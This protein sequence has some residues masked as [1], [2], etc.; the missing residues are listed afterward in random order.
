MSTNYEV[1]DEVHVGG[2]EQVPSEWMTIR[3]VFHNF[4]SLPSKLGDITKSPVLEC[5]GLEWKVQ[6]YPGGSLNEVFVALY[7]ESLSCSRTKKIKA[8]SRVRIPSAGTLKGGISGWDIF[9]PRNAGTEE[10]N[11]WGFE[12][13]ALRS[14]VLDPSTNYLVRGTCNLT[15]EIDIQIMLDKPPTWTPTN[16]VCS[17]MLKMLKSTDADDFDVTFQVGDD[18][19]ELF[20]A[21]RSI[22]KFRSPVLAD[23]ISDYPDSSTDIPIKDVEP[24]VFR[25]LLHFI[26]GG[27]MPSDVILSNQARPIIH[28]ADKYGCTGLKL[29]A[30]AKMAADGITAENAAELI[31]FA[32]ATN[33]V[34]L[35]EAAMEYFVANADDVMASEGFDQVKESPSILTELMSVALG[36]SKKRPASADADNNRDYKRMRVATLRQKLDDKKLDVDGSKEMLISRLEAADAEAEVADQAAAQAEAEQNN[37][38]D[39]EEE[40]ESDEIED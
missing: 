39:D 11:S 33:C 29:A 18:K 36:G 17:D 27:E 40:S 5:H 8:Q 23:F 28:A 19:S 16:T 3:A 6:L 12:T 32:D 31:L 30:E 34:M 2:Q 9:A 20:R 14:V 24:D 7:L 22:L 4:A 10:Y 13:Y 38:D 25:M 15:V 26:Y 37:N 21:H 35:K 1:V